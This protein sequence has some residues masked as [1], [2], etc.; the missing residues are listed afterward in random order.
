[1]AGERKINSFP[2]RHDL[3]QLMSS[4]VWRDQCSVVAPTV[5]LL[6]K[7]QSIQ[8]K[9]RQDACVKKKLRDEEW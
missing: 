3:N 7:N 6:Y 8:Q 5:F 1:M 9:G 2:C 4:N